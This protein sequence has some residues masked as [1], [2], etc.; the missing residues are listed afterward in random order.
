MLW[1]HLPPSC[2]PSEAWRCPAEWERKSGGRCTLQWEIPDPLPWFCQ[3][4]LTSG[5]PVDPS[6]DQDLRLLHLRKECDTHDWI[7]FIFKCMWLPH[8]LVCQ[9]CRTFTKI[10]L[11]KFH[12]KYLSNIVSKTLWPM[13]R[14]QSI[15]NRPLALQMFSIIS[16]AKT[17][18]LWLQE[19]EL[20]SVEGRPW[21]RSPS[22]WTP[23]WT[24]RAAKGFS[25]MSPAC[26]AGERAEFSVTGGSHSLAATLECCWTTQA[27]F[28]CPKAYLPHTVEAIDLNTP[29]LKTSNSSIVHNFTC[30]HTFVC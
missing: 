25:P 2:H 5:V 8:I 30:Y 15:T 21:G 26:W 10:Q 29:R 28:I 14:A 6:G 4:A 11:K 16:K 12:P 27:H 7:S 17:C 18:R 3:L 24:G 1:G 19:P 13:W 23:C 20:D 22:R 9:I